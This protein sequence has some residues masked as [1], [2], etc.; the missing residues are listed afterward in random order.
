VNPHIFREYDVRGLVDRDLEPSVMRGLGAALGSAVAARGGRRIALGRDVRESSPGIA[1]AFEEGVRGAGVDVVRLGTVPTPLV[2]WAVNTLDLDGGAQVTGSHNP[3]EYNGVKLM[4]GKETLFGP[5][6]QD[7]RR[8]IESGDLRRGSGSAEDRDCREDYL[9]DVAR[10]TPL[11]RPLRVVI[12]AGNGCAG[13]LAPELFRR[14]GCEVEGLFLEPDGAF[15]NHIPDPTLP[16]TLTA[17][18]E[19]V[20]AGGADLGIAYDG[21][22]DRVGAVDETGRIA[23][24]DELLALFAREV[25]ARR[26]GA[27]VLFEV[28]CSE[29]LVEDIRAHGG[30]P[31]MTRTGHS[32]I[33]KKM[34]ELG[35][36]LAGEMSGHLFFADD[37]YG[38]D[39]GIYAS[40]RLARLV[41]AAGEPLSALLARIPRYAASPEIRI[42]CA[43]DRKFDV[44]AAVLDRYRA[45]H[46]VVDVDGA[47]VTFPQGWG[48]VRASNT[49]PVLVVRAEGRTPR[50]RDAILEELR[51][52]L[53]ERG[54]AWP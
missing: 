52:A 14:L 8:R 43:D 28:K 1:A 22:A 27:P 39:D 20:L 24:G 47:R 6:I 38:F 11:A 3:P 44:V 33:K 34:K 40:A 2:Y 9:R 17:L 42:P 45:T 4:L 48:L 41:A 10:R 26:P 35:A 13:E 23:W 53:A 37:W 16:E 46:A 51:G 5:E 49:Q 31:V 7:L 32:L 36:P 12:D 25:L 50:E 19:R 21:D 15:P 18:R 54:V 29:A 30:D